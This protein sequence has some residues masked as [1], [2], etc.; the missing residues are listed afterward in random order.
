MKSPCPPTC[1]PHAGGTTFWNQPH[2]GRRMFFRHAAS[3]IGGYFLLPVRPWETVAY[4]KPPLLNSATNCIL[5]TLSG[6]PSHVDT[7]DLKVGPWTPASFRPTAY[8]GFGAFPQGL[9]PVI[10]E[11][12]P[13]IAIVRSVRSWALLHSLAY[14]WSVIARNP[15]TEA[16]SIAPHIGSVVARELA[17]GTG[18]PFLPPGSRTVSFI[19]QTN[20]GRVLPP[21]VSLNADDTTYGAGYFTPDFGPFNILS[22]SGTGLDDV[23]PGDYTEA[24]FNRRFDLIRNLESDKSA[25]QR[26]RE[27]AGFRSQARNMMFNPRVN[28]AF[29]LNADER[30]RYG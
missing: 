25:G 5:I 24:Q 10:A 4:A 13:Q 3:A 11:T 16:A 6:A 28:A 17:S 26:N 19:A 18:G 1:K 20:Q 15:S 8:P 21:F 7:F 22:L 9:M 23:A 29:T 30:R 27:L 2:I 12:L 14:G